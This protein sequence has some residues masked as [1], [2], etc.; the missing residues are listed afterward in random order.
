MAV[1]RWGW[2]W[3]LAGSGFRPLLSFDIV[4]RMPV[5]RRLLFEKL[6]S[7]YRLSGGLLWLIDTADADLLYGRSMSNL[8]GKPFA[9]LQKMPGN[10]RYG[11]NWRI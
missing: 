10:I 8:A 9:G 11:R 4:A 3:E 6:D 2:R 7:H 5:C 1:R